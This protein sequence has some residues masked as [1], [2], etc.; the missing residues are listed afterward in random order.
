MVSAYDR[1]GIKVWKWKQIV[2][3]PH[4]AAARQQQPWYASVQEYDKMTIQDD[5]DKQQDQNR[6][7]R[8]K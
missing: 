6:K 8:R 7:R 5:L 2:A 4:I 3:L 1:V